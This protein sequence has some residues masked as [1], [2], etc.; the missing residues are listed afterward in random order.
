MLLELTDEVFLL[1]TYLPSAAS[2]SLSLS[3]RTPSASSRNGQIS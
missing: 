3:S 1:D 2:S